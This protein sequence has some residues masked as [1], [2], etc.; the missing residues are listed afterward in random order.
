MPYKSDL[1]N[2]LLEDNKHK[3]YV[4]Y[5]RREKNKTTLCDVI[6]NLNKFG[7]KCNETRETITKDSSI[8]VQTHHLNKP[9]KIK[10]KT[11]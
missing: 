4:F 3:K 8:F 10:P 7:K 2:L 6:S 5:I 1:N 9:L 11:T